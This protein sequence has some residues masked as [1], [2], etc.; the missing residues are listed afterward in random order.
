MA[1]WIRKNS[2]ESE[3][4]NWILAN[5]K[6]CPKCKRPI[7]KNQGCM[8]MNCSQVHTS[9]LPL[10]PK[11]HPWIWVT[12]APLLVCT[13]KIMSILSPNLNRA[14]ES[15]LRYYPRTEF[16][17]II[18]IVCAVS[19]DLTINWKPPELGILPQILVSKALAV[20]LNGYASLYTARVGKRA[21]GVY[22]VPAWLV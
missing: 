2:A 6:P 9:P 19:H 4:L 11:L 18:I 20:D 14:Q 22:S 1:K 10:P 7:E 3:N 15:R 13:Y 17:W 16:I 5:T 8:H 12:N 21:F